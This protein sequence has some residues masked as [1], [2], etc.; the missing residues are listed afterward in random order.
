MDGMRLE[1]ELVRDAAGFSA[2]E[3]RWQALLAHTAWHS[4]FQRW[5]WQF[6]WWE[7]FGGELWIGVVRDG[8]QDV[9]ILPFVGRHSLAMRRLS[10]IGAPHSDYL[11]LIVREGYAEAVAEL[12]FKV[13]V[14]A[15]GRVVALELDAMNDRSALR[16]PLLQRAQQLGWRLRPR[17][18]RCPYIPL[19]ATWDEYLSDLSASS[20]Y[21]LRRKCRA[22]ARRDDVV[23]GCERDGELLDR[24]LG[25]FVTQHQTLWQQRGRPGAFADERFEQFHRRVARRLARQGMLRLHYLEIGGVPVAS[26]YLY[27]YQGVSAY[28]LSGFDPDYAE[29]SP[30]VVLLAE[31][32]RQA[33]GE[34]A[35]EFD[36]LRGEGTYKFH[37]TK[38]FRLNRSVVLLRPGVVGRLYAESRRFS[39]YAV[40]GFKR[41]LPKRLRLALRAALPAALVRLLDQLLRRE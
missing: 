18:K 2:L 20:R 9:A 26:Y 23:F 5:E 40:R 19:P 32:L 14:P 8:E 21:T 22:V 39:E 37:W 7:S 30:G 34:G 11:D 6:T 17:E 1:L 12:L 29:L 24:R 3:G 41:Y 33:I 36:L 13:F 27:H 10:L 38:L 25:D 4:L 35:Q 28:Y 31:A 15:V 16:E